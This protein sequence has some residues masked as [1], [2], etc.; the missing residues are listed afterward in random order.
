MTGFDFAVI[1]I[2]VLSALLAFFRGMVREVI[3]L[4][5]WV[6]AV[7]LAL[8]FEDRVAALLPT[9]E[10]APAAQHV[11]AFALVFVV[12]LIAGTIAALLLSRMVRAVG[13]G[14]L[15]RL[16]GGVFGV[17]RG[18]AIVLL[19]VLV[20]GLTALPRELW[21]QNAALGPL[22]VSSALALRP[23]LPPAWAE[24]LDYSAAGPKRPARQEKQASAAP[25]GEPE[26][27]VES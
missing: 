13:L 11:L 22:V 20:A 17:A 6:A 9:I 4:A 18:M 25:T 27:C 1:A 23:W 2:V 15:D 21:W 8:M 26:P 12:V 19:L 7:V 14:F 24:R 5:S 10:S 3:A 16:L